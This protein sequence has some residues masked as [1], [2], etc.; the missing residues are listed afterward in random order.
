MQPDGTVTTVPVRGWEYGPLAVHFSIGVQYRKFAVTHIQSG[1][2]LITYDLLDQAT[3]FVNDILAKDLDWNFSTQA[4]LPT[5]TRLVAAQML[6][7][8][9]AKKDV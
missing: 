2:L 4:Q 8:Q 6:N 7:G 9:R 5:R 3:R 1:M